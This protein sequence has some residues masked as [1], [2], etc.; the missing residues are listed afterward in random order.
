MKDL[1]KVESIS[2]YFRYTYEVILSMEASGGLL[3]RHAEISVLFDHCFTNY[4]R[5]LR[6]DDRIR[7]KGILSNENELYNI[8][9]KV[10][11]LKAHEITCVECKE[12]RG[13]LT[14]KVP[15]GSKLSELLKTAINDCVVSTKYI[16]NFLL[17][18]V[19]VFK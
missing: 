8:G 7:F 18:P 4:T 16:L 13:T 15:S 2:E 11:K 5:L 3:K 17:N 14:S 12:G 19:I 10:L 9:H 6:S 1:G